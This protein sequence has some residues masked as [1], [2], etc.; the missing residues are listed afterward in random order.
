M[1]N[2]DLKFLENLCDAIIN[3]FV[4]ISWE[5][6]MGIRT[7]MS[8]RLLDKIKKSGCY[9]LFIGLESGSNSVLQ[10]MCK[11]FTSKQAKNFFKQLKST[12]LNFGVSMIVGYPGETEKEY[13]ESLKFL[14]DNKEIIPKIE[15]IN[16]FVYYEGTKTDKQY[17]YR[18][19]KEALIR[20]QS[21]IKSLKEDKFKMTNA[22]LNNLVKN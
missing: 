6:Q 18:Y 1:V 21:M 10:R 9:N 5:A 2:I 3:N 15:Q 12:G 11:G 19:N 17:D 7:D 4:K 16:P 22:F 13:R 14:I 20:T 8:G